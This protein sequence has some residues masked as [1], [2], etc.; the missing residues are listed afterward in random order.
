MFGKSLVHAVKHFRNDIVDRSFR[1]RMPRDGLE[2]LEALPPLQGQDISLVVAYNVP[3]AIRYL[4]ALH[5]KFSPGR[6]LIVCDNSS[7]PAEAAEI[8]ALVAEAGA[9]YIRLPRNPEWNPS[10]S[11]GIAL[12]WAFQNVI[13]RVDPRSFMFLDHDMFQVGRFDFDA[14][15]DRQPFYGFERHLDGGWYLWAGYGG[16]RYADLRDL[17]LNFNHDQ[18]RG[19]DTGGRNYE[20]YFKSFERFSSRAARSEWVSLMRR[21]DGAEVVVNVFDDAF[22][23][24]GGVSYR[25]GQDISAARAFVTDYL[26]AILDG[27]A[28]DRFAAKVVAERSGIKM[29]KTTKPEV[30][31]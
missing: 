30:A 18:V 9:A 22:L 12:N 11:H 6:P 5:A 23:H 25:G 8:R 4:T 26:D 24:F 2:A 7:K 1:A 21:S 17:A 31:R 16:F 27:T 14:I 19:L 20:A 13:R 10:R 15:F 29:S 3:W 28:D